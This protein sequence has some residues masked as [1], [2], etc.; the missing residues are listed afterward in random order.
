MMSASDKHALFSHHKLPKKFEAQMSAAIDMQG[1][2]YVMP[3]LKNHEKGGV[4]LSKQ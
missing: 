4:N 1:I 2:N 3:Y